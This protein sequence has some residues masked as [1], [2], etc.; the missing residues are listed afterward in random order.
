[1]S[2]SSRPAAP[3]GA[4]TARQRRVLA[5]VA[6]FAAKHGYP[7]THAEIAQGLKFASPNAAREHLR[8]LAAK[9]WVATTPGLSRGLRLTAP[10]PAPA[11]RRPKGAT[12]AAP[13][14]VAAPRPEVELEA[15]LADGVGLPLVGRTAAGAPLLAEAHVERRVP[16]DPGAFR[17]RADYL[18]RV[19]GDSMIE[20]GILDGDFVAV[21]RGARPTPGATVVVRLDDETTVKRWRPQ[22]GRLV[23]EPANAALKPITV[24]PTR[25]SVAVEGVVVGVLRFGDG[26]LR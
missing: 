24:D 21:S 8:L 15:D 6:A 25:V 19:R 12:Q 2:P 5:F 23:L 9:G 26:G 3:R 17:P 11:G 22:G 4:P 18:L 20:A 14:A 13:G 1:M 10:P 7:P 16:I